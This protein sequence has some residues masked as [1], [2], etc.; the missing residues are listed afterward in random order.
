MRVPVARLLSLAILFSTGGVAAAQSDDAALQA[1]VDSFQRSISAGDLAASMDIVPPRLLA[2]IARR[3]GVKPS[4][5]RAAVEQVFTQTMSGI[6]IEEFGMDLTRA[7]TRVTAD[8]SRT[9]LLVPTY[10]VIRVKGGGRFRT[11][12][13]TLA[14]QDD[15]RWYLIRIDDLSQVSLLKA[16]YPEFTGADFPAG[17]MRA[18][19]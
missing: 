7:E 6:V 19:D 2:Q 5:V 17:S 10:T 8:G 3:F 13:H 11:D 4:E 1:R 9:Y 14:M 12:N 18:L 16:T 15:G